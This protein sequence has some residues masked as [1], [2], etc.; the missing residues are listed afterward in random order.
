ME[1]SN[2]KAY[3]DYYI[4]RS[5][6]AGMVLKGTEI[7]SIRNGSADLK[8][9]YVRIKNDEAFIINMYIAPYEKGNQFNHEERRS[10]KLLLHKK[11][12]IK[13]GEES[14]KDGYTIIPLK[15]YIHKGYAKLLIGVCKGKHLY[16]KRQS[17]KEKDLE[18]EAKRNNEY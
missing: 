9:A 14:K 15:L 17:I 7:K 1:I 11:E 6:E 2:R 16:D 5:I 3:F 18:K 10:R 13:L 4:E 8:D 12:I